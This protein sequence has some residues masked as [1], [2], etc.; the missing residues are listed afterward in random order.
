VLRRK[1]LR[2]AENMSESPL[3]EFG[4]DCRG[5]AGYEADAA[6]ALENLWMIM[7]YLRVLGWRRCVS[8]LRRRLQD[9]TQ[10]PPRLLGSMDSAPV[11]SA[12]IPEYPHRV[13]VVAA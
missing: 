4:K 6:L 5:Q 1:R 13:C 9:S 3:K 7:L 11:C 10:A 8:W 12:S 2:E